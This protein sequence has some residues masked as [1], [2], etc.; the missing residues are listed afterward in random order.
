MHAL[1]RPEEEAAWG[2]GR[3]GLITLQ[4]GT[5]TLIVCCFATGFLNY[6]LLAGCG[7]WGSKTLLSYLFCTLRPTG[8]ARH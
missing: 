5:G 2:Q 3:G 7:F 8:G 4:G 1:Q 6:P